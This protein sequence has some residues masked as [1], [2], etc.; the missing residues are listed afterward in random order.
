MAQCTHVLVVLGEAEDLD[1]TAET[2]IIEACKEKASNSQL[3]NVCIHTCGDADRQLRVQDVREFCGRL[4]C[5]NIFHFSGHCEQGRRGPHLV[6]GRGNNSYLEFWQ[7]REIL[8]KQQH[9]RAIVLNGC[10]TAE[11]A[12]ELVSMCQSLGGWVALDECVAVRPR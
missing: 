12:P 11:G 2:R 7:L 10:S 8:E 4:A 6:L 3:V 5:W 1:L 9:L